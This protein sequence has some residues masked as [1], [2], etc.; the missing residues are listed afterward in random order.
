VLV[1]V[2]AVFV[3]RWNRERRTARLFYDAADREVAERIAMCD[4]A[5]AWLSRSS[6]LWHVEGQRLASVP[7]EQ[8]R[9]HYKPGPFVEDGFAAPDAEFIETTWRYVNKSGGPDRRFRDNRQLPVFR[10]GEIHLASPLGVRIVLQ[11][12]SRA[13][14]EGA[15]IAIGALITR[16]QQIGVPPYPAS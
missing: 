1:M 15:A 8:L 12:S 4:G 11:T 9:V 16:A 5:G 7:Y 2:G 6:C 14:A 3:Y 13:C 10:Y